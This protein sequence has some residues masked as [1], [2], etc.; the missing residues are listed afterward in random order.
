MSATDVRRPVIPKPVKNQTEIGGI[1]HNT[2][3][4]SK[5]NIMQNATL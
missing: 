3:S 5:T 4:T 1:N 2:N